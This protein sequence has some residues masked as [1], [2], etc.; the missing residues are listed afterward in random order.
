MF[1]NEWDVQEAR[2]RF[3]AAETPN[4]AEAARILDALMHWTNQNSDGWPYWSKP[5]HAARK[6]QEALTLA[7]QDY[8]RGTEV[9]DLPKADLTKALAP[10]KAFLTKQGVAHSEVFA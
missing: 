6:V 5:S 3:D 4:L 1:M 9:T 2:E 7:T 10:I 8:Y